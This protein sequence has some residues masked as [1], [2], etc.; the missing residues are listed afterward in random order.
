[1]N[2]TENLMATGLDVLDRIEHIEKLQNEVKKIL[3]LQ[4]KVEQRN[5]F[6]ID[7]IIK[8]AEHISGTVARQ[9]EYPKMRQT[10][11]YPYHI[12]Q[13]TYACDLL[14]N[15]G[16]NKENVVEPMVVVEEEKIQYFQL[17]EGGD[18]DDDDNKNDMSEENLSEDVI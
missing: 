6:T 13:G 14:E 16:W 7:Q 9:P 11:P 17:D 10:H 8:Y 12:Q 5:V 1:M 4:N 3:E 2:S 15:V 18:F